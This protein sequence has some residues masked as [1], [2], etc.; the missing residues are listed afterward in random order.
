[1]IKKGDLITVEVT[2]LNSEGKGISKTDEGFVIFSEKTLPG[3]TAQIRIKK[4]KSNYAEAVL[5]E[6]VKPSEFRTAARCSHFGVCGGCKIQNYS[7]DKQLEFK[8]VVVQD[9][10][11]RIGGF[12]IPEILPALGSTEVFYYRNKM[13][14]SFSDD[15][16]LDAK[17]IDNEKDNYALGLHVPGFHSKIINIENCFLQS[18]LSNKIL[19][20]TYNFFKEKKVS[21]Y[22]TKT[23]SG[24]L[25][26]LII[27][28][29]KN[30]NDLMVNLITFEHDEKLMTE[31]SARLNELFPEITTIINSTTQKKAQVAFGE[32]EYILHG[33]GFITEILKDS[34]G[35]EFSFKISPQSFFQ[36]NTLQAEN[37]FRVMTEFGEF[38]KEDNVLDLYC[39]TGSVSIILSESVNKVKGVELIQDSINDAK[40]NSDLNSITNCEYICSDI[41]DFLENPESISGYNKLVLDPP[42]S[43]LHPKICE[44][45]SETEFEKIVYVSCNPHTQARDLKMICSRDKYKIEKIQPVDMFPHTYHIENIV[46]LVRKDTSQDS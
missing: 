33:K 10:L 30:T 18:E 6:L 40:I 4:K 2:S 31:Y 17:D 22:S 45:L 36:T 43:G 39:G 27:R 29:S 19:N 28:Q 11:Q 9:A 25:R 34:T 23:Q 37:L 35:K 16:W 26:F 8:T 15:E 46:S 13:E 41:K 1:M 32:N 14:Y 44:I 7:Y 42:R 24:M 12:D 20:F 3:D 21:V 38:G 5:V